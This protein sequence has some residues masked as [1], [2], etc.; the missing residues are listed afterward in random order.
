[1][2][3]RGTRG[4]AGLHKG[5]ADPGSPGCWSACTRAKANASSTPLKI[6]ISLTASNGGSGRERCRVVRRGCVRGAWCTCI[7]RSTRG[8]QVSWHELRIGIKR[9]RYTVENFLPRQ[10]ALWSG[11]LKELQ[12][13][14]GEVHDLDV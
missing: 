12:D 11:D 10:H 1:M 9:F 13:L 14:L 2:P 6:S 5:G 7:W 8:S 4:T 3:G